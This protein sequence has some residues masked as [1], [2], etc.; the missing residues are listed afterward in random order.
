MMETN[1][2]QH[3]RPEELPFIRSMAHKL[4]QVDTY[5]APQLTAFLNP[6]E[7]YIAGTLARRSGITYQEASL[8]ATGERKRLLF[9]PAYFEP[10]IED[11]ELSLLEIEYARKFCHLEHPQILGALLHQGLK[12]EQIGDIQT[13][14]QRFQIEVSQQLGAYLCANVEQIARNKV[15]LFEV[16]PTQALIS[17]D[18]A[19]IEKT[20][21]TSFRL[22]NILGNVYN[23]SRQLAKK[24]VQSE[25]VKVNFATC[26]KP[27]FILEQGDLVSIRG[28]GRFQ[29]KEIS[30]Q[31]TKKDRYHITYSVLRKL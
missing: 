23:I 7:R 12:R 14:G 3:F 10:Q 28:Y 19:S 9:Y 18:C 1:I 24:L 5:Y 25:K 16:P 30:E 22:D 29:L 20:T 11:F 4:Q 17:K 26:S 21:I 31:K 27:D 15:R 6:R 8:F 2:T 13:D